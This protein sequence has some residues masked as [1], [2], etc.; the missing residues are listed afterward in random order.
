MMLS[1]DHCSR[2][3]NLKTEGTMI[4]KS[5]AKPRKVICSGSTAA[6]AA[7]ERK[8]EGVSEKTHCKTGD[9]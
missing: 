2:Y 4:Y 5:F 6:V 9:T 1:P 7:Q 8:M 3:T